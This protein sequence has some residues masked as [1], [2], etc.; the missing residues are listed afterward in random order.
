[1]STDGWG[2]GDMRTRPSIQVFPAGFPGSADPGISR[3]SPFILNQGQGGVCKLHGTS[4][5]FFAGGLGVARV[6]GD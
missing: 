5:I 6:F 2:M 3:M 1:M 4:A